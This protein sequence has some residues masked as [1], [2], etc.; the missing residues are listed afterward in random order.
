LMAPVSEELVMGVLSWQ[1][2]LLAKVQESLMAPVSE[3]LVLGGAVVAG[4]GAGGTVVGKGAG[5]VDGACV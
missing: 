1:G 5:I 4:V 2:L 3:E